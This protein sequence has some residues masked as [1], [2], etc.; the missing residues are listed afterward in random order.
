VE[1]EKAKIKFSELLDKVR[2]H[3]AMTFHRFIEDSSVKIF[4]CGHEIEPWNPFCINENA[5]QSKSVDYLPGGATMKGYVLPHRN[6]FS[7]EEA[8]KK[9]EGINGWGAQQ[10]FY[11]YRGKRLLLAGDWLGIRRKEE[12][13]K[14]VRIQID[15]PNTLDTEW[16]IDIKKSRA[17]PPLFCKEQLSSYAKTVCADGCEVYR[18]RGKI[19][20]Q[21]AGQ[22]FQPLWLDKKKDNKWYFVVNRDHSIIQR[23]KEYA[24]ENPTKAIDILLNFIEESIPSKSIYL[25]ESQDEEN[26]KELYSDFDINT[27]KETMKMI[28]QK[29]IEDGM[30]PHQSKSLLKSIEPFNNFEDII[31]EL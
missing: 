17:Y 30:K 18:H 2:K 16:Q 15:L 23:M 21:R 8:Y 14:L 22:D 10:G 31:D 12:H 7:S 5:T 13:Y 9:A 28:Y 6:K 3:I 4:W 20:K 26:Q 1:D 19:L 25:K 29:H 24:K 11:V 27:I